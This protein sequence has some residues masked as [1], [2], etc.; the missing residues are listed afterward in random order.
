VGRREGS[1]E[2]LF[3]AVKLIHLP[4]EPAGVGIIGTQIVELEEVLGA[5]GFDY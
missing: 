1:G 3:L 2:P 5:L 4:D